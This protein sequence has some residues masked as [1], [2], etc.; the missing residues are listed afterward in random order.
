MKAGDISLTV[1]SQSDGKEKLRPVLLLS[2]MPGYADWLVCGI[3]SQVQKE[4][5]GWDFLI[6]KNSPCFYL[7]GLKTDSIIRLSF[8]AVIPSKNV[9]GKIGS[10]PPDIVN[11]LIKRL[12]TYL[13]SRSKNGI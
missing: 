1:L 5:K 10:L 4:L 13:Q 11:T 6:E 12:C 3:S 7:T 8:I 2:K 9:A